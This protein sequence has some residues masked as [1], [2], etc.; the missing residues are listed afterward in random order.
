[1]TARSSRTYLSIG[2]VL[3]LL[4]N[5]FPDVTISKIRFLE[6]QGLVSPERTSSGYRKFHEPD[7]ERL[8][9][10]L[11]HQREHFLP[12]KVIRERMEE[13]GLAPETPTKP[14]GTRRK[15]VSELVAALQESPP[16]TASVPEPAAAMVEPIAVPSTSAAAAHD[17]PIVP[18]QQPPTLTAEE[19]AAAAGID[20]AA[21]EALVEHGLVSTVRSGGMDGF[22]DDGVAIAKAASGFFALGL[23]PRHLK[24]LRHGVDR[25]MGMIETL[26]LPLLQQRTPEGRVRAREEAAKFARLGQSLRAAM[27]RRELRRTVG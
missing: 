13:A 23:E 17:D 27:L 11:R 1:M 3:S 7:V 2:E 12:L 9:F 5:D 6:G 14:P 20:V 19:A 21:L 10:V 22:D 18:R 24:V 8:R 25:E 4:R 15:S 16:S 26:V